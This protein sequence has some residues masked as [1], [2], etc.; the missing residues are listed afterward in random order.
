MVRDIRHAGYR[1]WHNEI[2]QIQRLVTADSFIIRYQAD[3]NDDETL[4]DT[5]DIDEDITYQFFPGTSQ[6]RRRDRNLGAWEVIANN[7]DDL[8]FTYLDANNQSILYENLTDL[9]ERDRVRR[10]RIDLR[11]VRRVGNDTVGIDLQTSLRLRNIYLP[12]KQ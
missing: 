5:N 9:Q 6:I 10:I 1:E 3:L 8:T 2:P 4:N 7:I 12:S 11:G